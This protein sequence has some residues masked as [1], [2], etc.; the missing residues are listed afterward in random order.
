MIRRMHDTYRPTVGNTPGVDGV[1]TSSD[2]FTIRL[3]LKHH[4]MSDHESSF[5]TECQAIRAVILKALKANVL[6]HQVLIDVREPLLRSEWDQLRKAAAHIRDIPK[7]KL[8]CE[9]VPNKVRMV[10]SRMTPKT[11]E[12]F[13]PE[14]QSDTFLTICR[15]NAHAWMAARMPKSDSLHPSAHR[16][17]GSLHRRMPYPIRPALPGAKR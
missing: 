7:N 10:H 14:Y 11:G 9:P 5:R 3:S 2:G 16:R 17:D 1:L 12:T 4:Y 13:A 8:I 6:A 15:K